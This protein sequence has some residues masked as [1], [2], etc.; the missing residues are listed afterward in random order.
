MLAVALVPAVL[1]SAI[2]VYSI[3]KSVRSEAQSRVNQDLEIV[4][5]SYREQLARLAYSLEISSSRVSLASDSPVD[6]LS[7]IRRELDLTVLNLC[8]AEGR[9]MAG[10]HPPSVQ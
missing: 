10:S 8:D 3:N 7:A 5:T 4:M 9:P 2:G 1:I 6:I